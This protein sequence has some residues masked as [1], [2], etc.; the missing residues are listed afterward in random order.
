MLDK[1]QPPILCFVGLDA[2]TFLKDADTP[3]GATF[4]CLAWLS[5]GQHAYL[6]ENPGCKGM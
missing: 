4:E 1:P 3:H 2:T 6:L 5:P